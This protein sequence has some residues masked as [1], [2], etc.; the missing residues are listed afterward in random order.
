ML[1]G[2]VVI[3]S[4]I[5]GQVIIND[6]MV[7]RYVPPEYRARA[8]SVRYFLGF[9]VAGFAAPVISLLHAKGGFPEVLGVAAGFGAVVA[10]AALAF[11][12]FAVNRAPVAA[13]A[14]PHET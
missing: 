6:A 3:M 2:L 9:T 13:T 5:Y 8:F 10:S 7:A 11:R 4:A 12:L 1:L 14:A